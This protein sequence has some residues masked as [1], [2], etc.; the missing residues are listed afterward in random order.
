MQAI[1]AYMQAEGSDFQLALDRIE[2]DFA[3]DLNSMEVQDRKM[4]EGKKQIATLLFKEW[5]QTR[6]FDTEE[7]D[8]EILESVNGAIAFYQNQSKKDFK[9][10]GNQMLNAVEKIYDHYLIIL[11]LAG[12]L[13]K[14]TEGEEVKKA[15]R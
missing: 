13:V 1:Y 6:Q 10:F 12:E 14:M 4:L 5:Y 7:T 15:T 2:E 11:M 9:F 3:P 8:K